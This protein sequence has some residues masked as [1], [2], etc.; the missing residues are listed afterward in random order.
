MLYSEEQ[1]YMKKC[2]KCETEISEE[3]YEL[4]DGLCNDCQFEEEEDDFLIG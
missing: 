2:K 4:N 3:E 1:K